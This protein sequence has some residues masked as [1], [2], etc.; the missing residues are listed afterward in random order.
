LEP[1]LVG[2]ALPDQLDRFNKLDTA[3]RNIMKLV[4]DAPKLQTLFD[5]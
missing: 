1:I 3:F 2:G 5:I 4:A